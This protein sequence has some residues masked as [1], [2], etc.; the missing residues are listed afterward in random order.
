MKKLL[1]HIIHYNLQPSDLCDLITQIETVLRHESRTHPL[2]NYSPMSHTLKALKTYD[3]RLT[4]SSREQDDLT[5]ILE[6]L[7]PLI[8]DELMWRNIQQEEQMRTSRA[9]QD[10][11]KS[12]N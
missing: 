5:A 12:N 2:R 9:S 1:A 6:N 3:G 4:L 8:V 10:R 11:N 7:E